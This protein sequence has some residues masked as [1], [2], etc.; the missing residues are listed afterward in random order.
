VG[1]DPAGDELFVRRPS[2]HQVVLAPL[3]RALNAAITFELPGETV[4][5]DRSLF[6]GI[7]NHCRDNFFPRNDNERDTCLFVP[8]DE[9]A[10]I[11]THLDTGRTL[12]F[13]G[14]RGTGKSTAVR[15][16]LRERDLQSER[17]RERQRTFLV[18]MNGL[19]KRLR[20]LRLQK[21][22]SPALE[23]LL[24]QLNEFRRHLG[25]GPWA[26]YQ[27]A[28]APDFARF[29][30]QVER[31]ANLGVVDS[32]A[33]GDFAAWEILTGRPELAEMYHKYNDLYALTAS[34]PQRLGHV[35][36]YLESH[37]QIA[38]NLALDNV[39]HLDTDEQLD[40]IETFLQISH[41]VKNL[42]T[43]LAVR[44][45]TFAQ[46]AHGGNR[47]V[48]VEA[49]EKLVLQKLEFGRTITI[50]DRRL[51]VVTL[52]KDQ[53]NAEMRS[54]PRELSRLASDLGTHDAER[55]IAD[56][57]AILKTFVEQIF[58]SETGETPPPPGPGAK[59]DGRRFMGYYA[60]WYNSSIRDIAENLYYFCEGILL[61][62][63]PI[64]G[65][66]ALLKEAR[67]AGRPIET[68]LRQERVF[69]RQRRIVR[70]LLFRHLMLCSRE[71]LGPPDHVLLLKKPDEHVDLPHFPRLRVLQLLANPA[72]YEGQR[73]ATV[74]VG[75][76]AG[77][78]QRIGI[79]VGVTNGTLRELWRPRYANDLGLIRVEHPEHLPD[80]R[81]SDAPLPTDA[82]VELLESGRFLVTDLA[83]TCEYLFWSA[84]S[85]PTAKAALMKA[86]FEWDASRLSDDLYRAD[87]A[88]LMIAQVLIPAFKLEHPYLERAP[89]ARDKLEQAQS[90]VRRY[91]SLF[92]EWFLKD[93]ALSLRDGFIGN[94]YKKRSERAPILE[95]LAD[96]I[97][98]CDDLDS[99]CERR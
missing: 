90:R 9:V 1:V 74:T 78:L 77:R 87:G 53:I 43:I 70:T 32:P 30:D 8:R 50:L 99:L 5:G 6:A 38:L 11:V 14:E 10:T 20:D 45:E 85:D 88:S 52:F 27:T 21:V 86:D 7:T 84:F 55:L 35:L 23:T 37:H 46:I 48:G 83:L 57:D 80:F 17:Q 42:T 39:D 69:S 94:R 22:A 95:R 79:D 93:V 98:L 16:A 72:T 92:G 44:T 54:Q 49:T 61:D 89:V 58:R 36:G 82:R 3:A 34:A 13:Y 24:E 4:K 96:A 33:E 29:R 67:A 40:L 25:D 75:R 12:I 26:G 97:K 62:R 31:L 19:E 71:A 47:I 63:E 59:D 65:L 91:H 73:G 64:F 76:I 15:A 41:E 2:S 18:D 66:A 68:E 60:R 51:R 81:K 28:V 56:L